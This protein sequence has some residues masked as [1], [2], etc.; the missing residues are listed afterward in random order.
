M[1]EDRKLRRRELLAVRCQKFLGRFHTICTP[2]KCNALIDTLK[3][4]TH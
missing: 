4:T 3:L 2:I 1:N